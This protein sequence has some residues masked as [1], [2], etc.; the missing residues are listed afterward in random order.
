MRCRPG[1]LAIIIGG[2]KEA[3][4]LVVTVGAFKGQVTGTEYADYWRVHRPRP[5]IPVQGYDGQ[6]AY[7]NW[8]YVRDPHLLPI[9]D[10]VPEQE[11]TKEKELVPE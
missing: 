4:G 1:I 11:V 10:P 2:C 7:Q 5:D 6:G 9:S 8:A 3:L